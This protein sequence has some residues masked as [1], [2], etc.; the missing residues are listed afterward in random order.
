[1]RPMIPHVAT[2]ALWLLPLVLQAAIAVVMLR[3]ALVTIF[4]I[5][6]SYTALVLSREMAL[7]FLRYPGDLYALVYWCGEALAVLLGLGVIFETIKH[8]FVPYPFLRILMKV[9]WIVGAIAGVTALMMLVLTNGGTGADRIFEFI[10]LAERSVRFLQACLLIVVTALMSRLGL[11]WHHYSVG[12]VAG[13]GVYSALD[14]GVLE[15]RAHLHFL[16]DARLV[17][18]TSVA[19]NFAAIIWASY[20]LRSWRRN[21]IEHLPETNLREWN[22]TVTEYVDQWY[23]H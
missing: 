19:Y 15:L 20:F 21:P 18:F 4:P 23:R 12:I 22:E 9:L 11:T 6:F 10:L 1:V 3:R 5:F 13:F 16:S 14:L 7:L 2:I 17:L 8:L